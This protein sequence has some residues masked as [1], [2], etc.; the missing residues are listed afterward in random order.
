M[1]LAAV[2]LL[3]VGGLATWQFTGPQQAKDSDV[4]FGAAEQDAPRERLQAQFAPPARAVEGV[5][6]MQIRLGGPLLIRTTRLA[7][8][9][10]DFDTARTE[11]ERIVAA[12]G[13]FVG[14]IAV[15]DARAGAR[16]L[17]A[18]LRIPAHRLD[19]TLA[20]LKGLGHVTSES[21]QGE[22]VTQQ[23]IDLD[24]RLS[25]AR[26]SEARLKNILETRTGRLSDVLDVEREITR[27][28]GEIEG[29]E[30]QRK[31]LDGRITYAEVIV[32]MS[33][34]RKAAVDFGPLPVRTRL[35]NALVDGWSSAATSALEA[36]LFVARVAPVL[37]LWTLVLAPAAWLLKRRFMTRE[38]HVDSED[39]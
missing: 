27:V 2:L 11:M 14:Q 26:A 25:N 5:P 23:S 17:G 3:A 33:E 31:A 15:S 35:R 39:E 16:S 4:M 24:A 6:E 21:Q 13:G 22:D 32:E 1:Q 18:T 19:G 34:E 36:T 30:A 37:L 12:A 10:H 8:V 29:M 20:S 9:P 7:L 28:R 38:Y